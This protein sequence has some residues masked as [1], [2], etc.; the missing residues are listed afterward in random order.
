MSRPRTIGIYEVI[1]RLEGQSREVY[2]ARSSLEPGR[3]FVLALFEVSEGDRLALEKEVKHCMRVDHPAVTRTVEAFAHEGKEVLVFE[4]VVGA[5]LHSLMGHLDREG[6]QLSD[7]AILHIGRALVDALEASHGATDERDK[8]LPLVH[9][10]LNPYQVLIAWNGDVKLLGVG[11]STIFRLAASNAQVPAEAHPYQAPEVR[12][13]GQVT[14]RANVYSAAALLWALFMGQTPPD[15]EERLESLVDARP[16][17]PKAVAK[18]LDQALEPAITKRTMTCQ[19]LAKAFDSAAD[20]CDR[21]DLK[22]NMEVFRALIRVDEIM[23]TH[24]LPPSTLSQAP[25]ESIS[26]VPPDS[27]LPDSDSAPP[28]RSRSL[29]DPPDSFEPFYDLPTERHDFSTFQASAASSKQLKKRQGAQPT[30]L[31]TGPAVPRPGAT[32]GDEDDI[33]WDLSSDDEAEPSTLRATDRP[34]GE[35]P[36][37]PQETKGTKNGDRHLGKRAKGNKAKA[38]KRPDREDSPDTKRAQERPTPAPRPADDDEEDKDETKQR[39]QPAPP[40]RPSRPRASQPGKPPAPRPGKKLPP[41]RAGP[42]RTRARPT[43]PAKLPKPARP[44]PPGA[45]ERK[46]PKAEPTPRAPGVDSR[47]SDPGRDEDPAARDSAPVVPTP[48]S[49]EVEE[50][51]PSDPDVGVTPTEDLADVSPLAPVEELPPTPRSPTPAPDTTESRTPAVK[52]ARAGKPA[53]A[54]QVI[55][56]DVANLPGRL[57]PGA[58]A[59]PGAPKPPP[60]DGQWRLPI[61]WLAVVAITALASFILGLLVSSGVEVSVTSGDGTTQPSAPPNPAS[62][63][64]PTAPGSVAPTPT[65][66]ATETTAPSAEPEKADAGDDSS[67]QS[68][69]DVDPSTLPPNRG[70]LWVESSQQDGEVYMKGVHAGSV[71]KANVVPCGTGF[72]RLGT[73]PLTKWYGPGQVVT[74]PCQGIT[75]LTLEPGRNPPA[76]ATPGKGPGKPPSGGDWVPSTL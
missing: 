66:T 5:S 65:P 16:E 59:A 53:G 62:P 43:K 47:P 72:V 20:A 69:D 35:P 63:T 75:K 70:Y 2:L 42:D 68:G 49:G 34:S 57:P 11:L 27:L 64:A 32:K 41:R 6:E 33:D 8:P 54:E 58:V 17:I 4:S 39:R 31:G 56:V 38:V 7:G 21:E 52:P 61:R 24:S 14:T 22:W 10:Q 3:D 51:R 9:G 74:V 30:L 18:A 26:V 36:D 46:G 50:L 12:N 67:S 76:G 23:P 60:S 15:D 37:E 19:Q 29:T 55:R 13:G 48:S 71:G 45:K 44:K 25:P 28:P 40:A 1:R 73:V